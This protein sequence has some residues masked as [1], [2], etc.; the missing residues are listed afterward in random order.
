MGAVVL[1]GASTDL[2]HVRLRAGVKPLLFFTRG[3]LKTEKLWTNTIRTRRSDRLLHPWQQA[4][5]HAR[6]LIEQFTVPGDLVCDPFLGSGTTAVVAEQL[7]R[8]FVGCDID[9]QAVSTTTRRLLGSQSVTA[10]DGTSP[11]MHPC[12]TKLI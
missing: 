1:D 8:H 2:H 5:E 12:S 6:V 11:P 7:G 9:E 4:E 10:L 3:A